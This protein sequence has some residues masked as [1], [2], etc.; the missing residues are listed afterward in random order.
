[1]VFLSIILFTPVFLI[2]A[3]VFVL[4]PRAPSQ[5]ARTV[6]NVLSL[7]ISLSVSIAAMRWGF[8]NADPEVGPIWRQVL[9]TLMA[10]GAFL[11]TLSLA[12]GL[13]QWWLNP[14]KRKHH[15]V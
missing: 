15:D 6:F 1:M 13:R 8:L 7:V 9:A 14:A 5:P 2:L 4:F 12:F 3:G 10:Y 11:L